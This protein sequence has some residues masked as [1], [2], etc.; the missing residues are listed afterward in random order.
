MIN[1]INKEVSNE[2]GITLAAL[3]ITVV[4]MM[5]IIGV[6]ITIGTDS[7]DSTRLQGFYM[8]LET[9]QKRVDDIAITNESY[10]NSEGTTIYIKEQGVEYADLASDKQTALQTIVTNEGEGLITN[11]ETFRYFTIAELDDILDLSSIE[12]NVFIDFDTRTIIAENGIIANGESY[13]ILKNDIYYAQQNKTK[14]EG[15][16]TSLEYNV[17]SYGTGKYK[18]VIEPSNS[19]GDLSKS[20]RVEYKKTTTKYWET[21]TNT[22]IILEL[23]VEYNVKYIDVNNNSLERTIKVVLDTENE[24]TPVVQEIE[25]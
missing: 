11:L 16:I 8:Q 7:L 21:S 15:E 22:E 3:I 4:V 12:Y 17:F 6:S 20:G 1:N 10:I 24:N 13:H 25:E 18:V 5:L 9:I 19:V 2:K 14:N 23:D